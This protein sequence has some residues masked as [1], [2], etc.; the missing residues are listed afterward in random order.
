[1]TSQQVRVVICKWLA[2][3]LCIKRPAGRTVCQLEVPVPLYDKV[4][5][6][7]AAVSQLA[8]RKRFYDS[9]PPGQ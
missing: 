2:W 6:L 1:M 7:C 5:V 4:R 3:L 8:S 9:K